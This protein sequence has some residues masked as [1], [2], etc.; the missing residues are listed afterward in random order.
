MP[1]AVREYR[2]QRRGPHA[3]ALGRFVVGAD[4]LDAFVAARK[5]FDDDAW[6]LSLL[7]ADLRGAIP[8]ATALAPLL[9]VEAIEAKAAT[10]AEVTALEPLTTRAREVYVELPLGDQ[11][12][13]LVAAVGALGARAKIRTGGVVPQ[14]FPA[15]KSVARFICAC[16]AGG[17]RFK[18]TAG[19]HHLVRGEYALTYEK[20]SPT[21]TMFGYLNVLLASAWAYR[22]AS[23][24]VLV[25]VL[26][27][28][29][30]SAFGL[31]QGGELCWRDACLTADEARAAHAHAMT[32]VGSCSFHE[33]IAELIAAGLTGA[34]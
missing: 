20:D 23:A 10:V 31:G 19:L 9:R 17:V 16:V 5:I 29:E 27:E 21:A 15:A 22:G 11:L 8:D 24:E 12:D 13:A 14:A 30:T 34:Q 18:A 25:Q 33:P 7:V 32:G 3:W 4:Q 1:D 28:R 2:A 6:P 26:E